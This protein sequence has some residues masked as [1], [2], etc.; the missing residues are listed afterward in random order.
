M[1]LCS[2]CDESKPIE[3]FNRRGEGRQAQCRECQKGYYRARPQEHM[4]RVRANTARYIERNR[5][6]VLLYLEGHPCVDCGEADVV[7]LEFDHVRGKKRTDVSNLCLSGHSLATISAEIAKCE[8]RCANCHRRVTA[9]R[10]APRGS[11]TPDALA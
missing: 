2:R 5:G 1:K 10:R 7:V 3:A 6:F 9:S 4:R 8:V 11:R